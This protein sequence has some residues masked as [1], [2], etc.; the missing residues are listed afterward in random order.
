MPLLIKKGKMRFKSSK[1][2]IYTL[3]KKYNETK[4]AAIIDCFKLVPAF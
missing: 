2:W 1:V 4:E 3:L